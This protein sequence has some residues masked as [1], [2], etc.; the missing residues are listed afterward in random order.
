MTCY[1]VKEDHK[2]YL[3]LGPAMA[4]AVMC[5]SVTSEF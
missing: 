3:L 1:Y 2:L 5:R 4:Q